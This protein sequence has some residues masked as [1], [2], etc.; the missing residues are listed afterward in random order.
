MI[1]AQ[2]PPPGNLNQGNNM[3]DDSL[4]AAAPNEL[5]ALAAL[6]PLDGR[7]HRKVDD[8]RMYFSE[9]ALLRARLEVEVEWLIYLSEQNAVEELPDLSAADKKFLRRLVA[10]F[11]LQDAGRI[12]T[13]EATTNHDVKAVEYFL[14]E[15]VA[16]RKALSASSEF[17]HFACTSED[18]NNLA[19]ALNIKRARAE[20]VAPKMRALVECLRDLACEHAAQPML[21]RTHGQPASPTTVGKE[22]AVVAARLERACGDFE[23]VQVMGKINGASGNF[24]A[25]TN[26]Y[27]SID[28]PVVAADFVARLGLRYQ[29]LTT[30]IEPHD[31]IAALC[32][33]LCRFNNA[34]IDFNRDVWGYIALDYFRQN[35]VAGEIGSS[36]MP[37]KVNPIDFENS[38]GN[39]GMSCALLQ[40]FA[41]MLPVSRWQRDLSDSTLLRNLGVGIGH[42]VLAVDS[43]LRGLSKLQL[44]AAQI[45]RDLDRHWEVLAEAVQ[46]VMRR[47]GV[48][49]PYEKLA[50]LTRGADGINRDTLHAFIDALPIPDDAKH[51]LRA[52]TPATYTGRAAQLAAGQQREQ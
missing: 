5:G 1:A 48:E 33:A 49:Q 40:H 12:K 2:H 47:Y 3:T 17:I 34:L 9:F 8:L 20:V 16:G 28:W 23:A 50:A 14:K 21:A 30:Q 46:T 6:S 39:L 45:D 4:S 42:S 35:T 41:A 10:N 18:I 36:A 11:S 24:N 13:I 26:A 15:S 25:H 29:P 44:N 37:H 22:F 51:R 19:Y 43:T 52:L 38:E 7:Y 32:H 27:P 31:Y